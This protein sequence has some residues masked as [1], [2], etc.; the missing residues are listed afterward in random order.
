MFWSTTPTTNAHPRFLGPANADPRNR[1]APWQDYDGTSVNQFGTYLNVHDGLPD[2]NWGDPNNLPVLGEPLECDHVRPTPTYSSFS[3]SATSDE[4]GSLSLAPVNGRGGTR[5]DSRMKDPSAWDYAPTISPSQLRINPSPIPNSSSESVHTTLLT[6]NNPELGPH[7]GLDQPRQHNVP[8]SKHPGHQSRRELPRHGR[9]A[10]LGVDSS[11][12]RPPPPPHQVPSQKEVAPQPNM[13]QLRPRPKGPAPPGGPKSNALTSQIAERA[14]K[15]ELLIRL[16][17]EGLSYREIRQ[18][19]NFKEAESTLRGRW[20]TLTKAKEERKRK[21]EWQENDVSNQTTDRT[22]RPLPAHPFHNRL[23]FP[24]CPIATSRGP[25][26]H[27]R[28]S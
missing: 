22:Q 21:P 27:Q 26:C 17:E 28:H 13:G 9:L 4:M 5:R 25:F 19:G 1:H 8:R 18:Q 23:T 24:S 2:P 6:S 16:K 12:N 20:R 14:A 11:A 3:S 10:S 15:D 7:P